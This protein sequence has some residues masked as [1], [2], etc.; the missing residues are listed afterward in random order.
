MQGA[1]RT[2]VRSS[3]EGI[4]A[5]TFVLTSVLLLG[6]AA[7][8]IPLAM[9]VVP[10]VQVSPL[11]RHNQDA[12]SLA[13]AAIFL[14]M[15]PIS[16][17]LVPRF[18]AALN[19]RSGADAVIGLAAILCLTLGVAIGFVRFSG[20]LPWGYG[21]G[22]AAVVLGAWALIAAALLALSGRSRV[23]DL[24]ARAGAG[25]RR[26]WTLAAFGALMAV[27]TVVAWSH[28][29]L[30]VL[31]PGLLLVLAAGC[32]AVRGDRIRVPSIGRG[33]GRLIDVVVVL[34]VLFAVPD[35]VIFPVGPGIDSPSPFITYVV[36]FHQN[37]FLGPASQV[38][39]GQ[40]LLVDTVS[41][42]G[43]G[44][45]YLISAFFEIAPI[46]HGTLGFLD[47]FLSAMVIACGY[48]ILRLCRVGRWLAI[49]AMAVAVIVLAWGLTY[50][51]GGLLQHGAI[52]YGL[53]ILV[54]AAAVAGA[55]WSRAAGPLRLVCLFLVGLSSIWALEAFLYTLLTWLGLVAL[56]M[57]W[58]GREG[59]WRYLVRSLLET[60][61]AMVIVHVLFALATL[62]ASGELP[63]W[64]LY[65]TY[66]REF[67]TGDIGDLTYDYVPW[68]RGLGV[69]A[70][71]LVA[72]IGL[73]LILW[74]RGEYARRNRTEFVALT[75]SLAYGIALYTYFVNRSLDHV[76]PYL[77]LPFILVIVLALSLAFREGSPVPRVTA[78]LSLA[79]AMLI[80]LLAI[81]SVAPAIPDRASTSMLGYAIPGGRSLG[82]GF[83][84]LWN[85]PPLVAGA[86]EGERLLETEMPGE[87][88]S[89]VITRSDLGVEALA[90]A[91]RANS[92]GFSDPKENS[93]VPEPNLPIITA[94]I[95][96]L[97]PGTLMLVDRTALD[98][99]E[100]LRREPSLD[101]A[102][103]A[104]E[105][106]LEPLQGIALKM[107]GEKY[108]LVPVAEGDAG[109]EV[110]RLEPR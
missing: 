55:R 78:A 43:I 13:F 89:A 37:L 3:D 107:I 24:L 64:N 69:G 77:L 56:E 35:M 93:W 20:E 101:A 59:W 34:L 15:L 48:V 7:L 65:L 26:A 105:A 39:D 60:A 98:F 85:P 21:I 57:V 30:A 68:S 100:R 18:A 90:R 16:I 52:R 41:Q 12:E 83:D 49:P 33:W 81:S 54:I 92:L 71:Y 72:S 25:R 9:I 5:A 109:L 73:V 23:A 51:I 42:Y 6:L 91:G 17:F 96:E 103:A 50:P 86:D 40:V 61:A 32:A 2:G 67:V 74:K 80:A 87:D 62:I 82:D 19:A 28:V 75:G 11:I 79:G 104:P 110:V 14:A 1:P 95:E 22:T 88:R 53:P 63:D 102:A 27:L 46:G 66:L 108:E 38:L 8:L 44:N 76:L 36:Q 47:G 97:E 99:F 58:R 4:F 31:L 94:A 45:I 10:E 106:G 70:F 29:D 84:R